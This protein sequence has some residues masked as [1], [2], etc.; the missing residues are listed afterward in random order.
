MVVD[1][2][3]ADVGKPVVRGEETVGRVAAVRDGT[4]Y[5][6]PVLENGRP[7]VGLGWSHLAVL[8]E[9]YPLELFVIAHVHEDRIRFRRTHR[10]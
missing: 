7:V 8:T 2:A 9:T 1:I 5:V 3:E 4:A 6:D 10:D